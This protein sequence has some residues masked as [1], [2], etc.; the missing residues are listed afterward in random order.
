M[1]APEA[2]GDLQ[3]VRL[4]GQPRA[5]RVTVAPVESNGENAHLAAGVNDTG[6]F[7]RGSQSGIFFEHILFPEKAE[8]EPQRHEATSRTKKNQSQFSCEPSGLCVF[9]AL[10]LSTSAG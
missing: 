8:E 9:V 2:K 4:I 6:N 1:A 5:A 7:H 10:P 3:L